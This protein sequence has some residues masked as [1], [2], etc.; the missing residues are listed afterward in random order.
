MQG[1][2]AVQPSLR[3]SALSGFG[4]HLSRGQGGG[5]R[6]L[7]CSLEN[8]NRINVQLLIWKSSDQISA[9]W[10]QYKQEADFLLYFNCYLFQTCVLSILQMKRNI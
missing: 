1:N 3:S 7:F 2:A 9:C 8:A 5:T 10:I 6:A 4:K